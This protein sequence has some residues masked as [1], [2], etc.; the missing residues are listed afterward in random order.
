MRS[1]LTRE[2]LSAALATELGAALGR[3]VEDRVHLTPAEHWGTASCVVTVTVHGRA[4]G[5]ITAWLDKD[6]LAALVA[7]RGQAGSEQAVLDLAAGVMQDALDA[8]LE[9]PGYGT[10]AFGAVQVA[11][12]ATAERAPL[13]AMVATL[14]GGTRC[15][16]AVGADVD[17]QSEPE[18]ERLEAVLDFELPLVVR[19]GRS[20]MPLKGLAALG[21]GAMLDL[22]RSPDQPVE[23]V[24]GEKVV[25]LGEVVVVAGNYGVRITELTGTRAAMRAAAGGYGGHAC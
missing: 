16:L 24:M 23:L 21:P 9:Q 1:P 11:V 19:F 20:V 17:V 10:L 22:G 5:G 4:R 8:L 25:A 14:A 13:L 3:R 15:G 2:R 12:Q 18:D 6:A 7:A